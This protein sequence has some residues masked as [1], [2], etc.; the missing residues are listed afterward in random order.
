MDFG[1]LLAPDAVVLAPS[2]TSQKLLFEQIGALLA[3]GTEASAEAVAVALAEREQM[4]TTGFGGGAAIPHG[5]VAGLPRL[6]AA[7][8]RL[9]QPLDWGAV[10]GI[11]VDLVV[12]VVGPETAGADNLKALA[13]VSRTLRDRVLVEKIRGATD[14][15]ALWALLTGE[16]RA[17]A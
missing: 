12:A 13:L 9:S 4:G 2:A 17:A 6:M 8:V 15:G 7:V 16:A 10:D 11:P 3:D 1:N 5:R 14:A